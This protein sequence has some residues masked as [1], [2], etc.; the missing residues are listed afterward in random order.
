MARDER[1][2]DDRLVGADRDDVPQHDDALE[3]E[4]G[5]DEEERDRARAA[6]APP[7]VR[8]GAAGPGAVEMGQHDD[9]RR[10]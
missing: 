7:P 1:E 4:I 10:R 5:G 2:L 9:E 3:G 8:S 6:Q